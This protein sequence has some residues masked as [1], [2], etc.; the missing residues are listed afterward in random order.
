MSMS[1]YEDIVYKDYKLPFVF[2]TDNP[3]KN[4]IL[5]NWHENIEI[6]YCI[7]GNGSIRCDDEEFPLEKGEIAIIETNMIH[8]MSSVSDDF[9]YRCLIIDKCFFEENGL[10]FENIHFPRILRDEEMNLIFENI[11][12][13]FSSKNSYKCAEIRHAV[14][15]FLI[16]L[17][18]KYSFYHEEEYTDKKGEST[19]RIKKVI[20][21]LKKNYSEKI[22]LDSIA[23][24][25]NTSKFHLSREFK[26]ITGQTIFECLNFIRCKEAKRLIKDGHSV[27]NAAFSC[28]FENMSYFTR[29]YKKFMGDLPSKVRR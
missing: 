4:I 9:T 28:G 17:Y 25:L 27:S 22:T 12:T 1:R 29:T 23:N 5:S 3:L 13:A 2:H 7:S 26:Q 11:V 24:N 14:L 10:I 18:E 20:I 8:S 21:Y 15:G 6:L 19:N 16:T